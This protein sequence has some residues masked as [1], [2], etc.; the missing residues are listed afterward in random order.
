MKKVGVILS[1]CG[2]YDGAEIHESVIT[3]LAIDQMDAESLCMAPNINQMH[4]INHLTGSAMEGENRNVLVE[5]ARIARGKVRDIR[6]ITANDF[7]AL[8]IPGGFGAAKNLCDFAV[9]GTDCTIDPEVKR[10]VSETISARKPL[11]AIC[12]SPA[13]LAAICKDSPVKPEI[14]IGS[15]TD[16]ANAINA[17]GS[18]HVVCQVR[19][20]VVDRKNKIV[21]TP[22]YMLAERIS[23]AAEGIEKL[24]REVIGLIESK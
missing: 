20:F 8:I 7:D 19:E 11:G 13:L 21:T 3:L 18:T 6:E 1:G 15:D 23:E 17:M 14:T 9:K 12:I 2:V 4:V 5:S 24:V 10:L 22:A 16:T